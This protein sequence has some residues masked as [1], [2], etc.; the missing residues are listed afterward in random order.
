MTTLVN[1]ESQLVTLLTPNIAAATQQEVQMLIDAE[2][3]FANELTQLA[4]DG[5]ASD[6]VFQQDLATVV[7]IDSD[8]TNLLAQMYGS[9]TG[10][11]TT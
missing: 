11:T 3:Q 1:A 5:L 8:L 7:S 9:G 4:N 2:G 10:G 6:A